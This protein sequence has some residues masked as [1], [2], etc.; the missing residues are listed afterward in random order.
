MVGMFGSNPVTRDTGHQL[1]E[2]MGLPLLVPGNN[3]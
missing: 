1:D 2:P 3:Q